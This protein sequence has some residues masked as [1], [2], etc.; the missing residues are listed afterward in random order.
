MP[1]L[2]H[3]RPWARQATYSHTKY[4]SRIS[5]G[6]GSHDAMHEALE[7]VLQTSGAH[8]VGGSLSAARWSAM[9]ASTLRPLVYTSPFGPNGGCFSWRMASTGQHGMAQPARSARHCSALA[10]CHVGRLCRC[11]I[12]CS[13]EHSTAA[14]VAT[15]AWHSTMPWG[16]CGVKGG[17]RAPPAA[18]SAIKQLLNST[19]P[20]LHSTP[21][22][23][24]SLATI[25]VLRHTIR[26][27]VKGAPCGRPS[28]C[29]AAHSTLTGGPRV[30]GHR[31]RRARGRP[32][33][34]AD[35]RPRRAA[36]A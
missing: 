4:G 28:V 34:T 14:R 25:P 11:D 10:H 9:L 35:C 26:S 22:L 29:H 33:P 3:A 32:A 20:A 31:C 5:R 21:T 6:R 1:A 12:N 27:A 15:Y 17:H 16:C 19:T 36:C 2:V 24:R 23:Q 13:T 30:T 8:A 7:A 18:A